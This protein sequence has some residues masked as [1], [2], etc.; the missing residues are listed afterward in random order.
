MSSNE[1]VDQLILEATKDFEEP[2]GSIVV[3]RP[4]LV[5]QAD[6]RSSIEL[7]VAINE[8]VRELGKPISIVIEEDIETPTIWK[9]N[10]LPTEVVFGTHE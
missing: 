6:V 4:A 8:R 2:Q 5:Q 9:I 3:D 7:I 1:A 10:W